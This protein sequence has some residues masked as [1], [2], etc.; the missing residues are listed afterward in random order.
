M[1]EKR[2]VLVVIDIGAADI[3]HGAR[4]EGAR[5]EC[6]NCGKET[7]RSPC[8]HCGY[9]LIVEFY[10]PEKPAFGPE[11]SYVNTPADTCGEPDER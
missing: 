4:F 7:A 6:P 11:I 2:N 8:V 1:K 5:A 3:L 9:S 10:K